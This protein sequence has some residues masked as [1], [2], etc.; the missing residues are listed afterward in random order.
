MQDGITAQLAG[1]P[2]TLVEYTICACCL[3]YW[4]FISIPPSIFPNTNSVTPCS[5]IC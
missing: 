1:K 5:S 2:C 4:L 3:D